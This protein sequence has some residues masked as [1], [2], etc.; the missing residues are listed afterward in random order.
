MVALQVEDLASLRPLYILPYILPSARIRGIRNHF[1]HAPVWNDN[2][3]HI[4]YEAK[5]LSYFGG[6]ADALDTAGG[7]LIIL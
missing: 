6:G 7:I 3:K 1:H 5:A 4:Q 2:R